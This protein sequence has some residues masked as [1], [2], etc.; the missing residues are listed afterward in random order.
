MIAAK[1]AAAVD[2]CFLST[3]LTF[4]TPILVQATCDADP[5]L[6]VFSSPH[7]VAGGPVT[8]NILKCQLKPLVFSDY[9]G[10]TF[11]AGQQA[12]LQAVFPA[13]V[14]DWSKPGVGQQDPAVSPLN[15]QAGPG[16]VPLL[17]DP[18]SFPI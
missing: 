17:P 5:R 8:E 3:D 7:R 14:C 15:F 16:G 9:T 12:R 2:F 18:V 13:G 1:P 10:I 4:S 6:A 11:T